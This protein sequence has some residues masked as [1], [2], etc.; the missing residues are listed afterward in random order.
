MVLSVCFYSSQSSRYVR[1]VDTHSC[2]RRGIGKAFRSQCEE[3]VNSAR[4][5]PKW[6]V[7]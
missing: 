4:I 6:H 7:V 2:E 3:L 5:D 1:D